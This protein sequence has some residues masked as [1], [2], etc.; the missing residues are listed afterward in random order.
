M[1]TFNNDLKQFGALNGSNKLV[2]FL[3]LVVLFAASYFFGKSFLGKKDMTEVS[4]TAPTG[5]AQTTNTA[6]IAVQPT[7]S[8]LKVGETV[9]IAVALSKDA[10][11][12]VD[13]IL[14]FDPKYIEVSDVRAGKNFPVLIS[15]NVEAGKVT[16]S[17]SITP[18]KATEPQVGEV[19]VMTVKALAPVD[20]TFLQFDPKDT[21]V[22][23]DGVNILN[24]S[25]GA[26]FAIT[27]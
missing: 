26:S 22:A 11:Q 9:E 23:K 10:A 7:S 13:V 25:L 21:I 5:E 2:I 4:T 24:S 8:T 27:Q 1:S 17:S 15:Q 18:E 19:A 6:V 16:V 3:I 20:N 12:A 14:N